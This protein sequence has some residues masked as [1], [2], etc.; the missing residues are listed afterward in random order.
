EIEREA[1]RR[2][3]VAESAEEVVVAAAAAD[4]AGRARRIQIEDDAGVVAEAPDFAE[5]DLELGAEIPGRGQRSR[6]APYRPARLVAGR[7][8]F[9]LLQ[10]LAR[11]GLRA[12]RFG[13]HQDRVARHTLG[14]L[15]L[16]ERSQRRQVLA[17]D[18]VVEGARESRRGAGGRGERR[19]VAGA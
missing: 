19:E 10:Q 14:D 3:R 18:R 1:D 16:A 15:A 6:D 5:I 17:I 7:E 8:L 11:P 12:R 4:G 9:R 13:E 2:A